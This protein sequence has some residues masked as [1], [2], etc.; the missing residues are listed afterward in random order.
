MT[1]NMRTR[2]E[3]TFAELVSVVSDWYDEHIPI[4]MLKV[5][6]RDHIGDTYSLHTSSKTIDLMNMLK[7]FCW[8]PAD[9]TLLYDTIKA[10][11]QFGLEH[12]IQ[13]KMP[14][15]QIDKN[16][17]DKEITVFTL[18]RQRLVKLGMSLTPSDVQKISDLYK[19]KHTDR[20]SLIMDLEHNM[21]ICEENMDTFI[22]KLKTHNLHQAVKSLTEDIPK[23][24]S[25]PGQASDIPNPSSNPGLAC[26]VKLILKRKREDDQPHPEYVLD[27]LEELNECKDILTL[28]E[29]PKDFVKLRSIVSFYEDLG[30]DLKEIGEESIVFH[31]STHDPDPL[32]HLW[33]IHS[34]GTLIQDL[35]D[36]LVPEIHQQ[37]FLG[38]WMT[39]IDENQYK[40]ALDNLKEEEIFDISEIIETL[41][42][43]TKGTYLLLLNTYTKEFNLI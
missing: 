8:S 37:E 22:D 40:A 21:V 16:I 32:M 17:R 10:T 28:K 30:L 39:Y 20:W 23:P 14:S 42:Q 15:F 19:V 9:L 1:M 27:L 41:R 11:K 29:N 35:A 31:L 24:S 43:F 6:F 7:T 26:D 38:E 25:N 33:E 18:H 13:N 36:I 4:N 12:D 5:L 34:S 2:K 3:S